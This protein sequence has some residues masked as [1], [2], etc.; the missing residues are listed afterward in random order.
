MVGVAADTLFAPL[1]PEG[2]VKSLM[3]SQPVGDFR[4][5][6]QALKGRLAS[7]KL[8]ATRALCC[9]I[10]R[11]VSTGQRAWRNL[12]EGMGRQQRQQRNR[13]GSQE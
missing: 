12:G 7:A 1:D 3:G 2:S 10:E 6:L 5:A 11:L 8:M 4:V 9:A 13:P